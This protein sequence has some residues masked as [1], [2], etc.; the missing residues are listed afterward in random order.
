MKDLSIANLLG[1]KYPIFQGGIAWVSDANLASA[2]SNAGGLGIIAAGNAD[3]NWLKSEI[4]KA[5]R[6]TDKPLGVNIMLLSP[7]VEEVVKLVAESSIEVI[8]TGAGNPGPYIEKWQEAGK[9]VI[10]VVSS[11]ALAKRLA[12]KGVDA[13]IAEGMEAGGHIGTTTTMALVPQIR[14]AINI[15]VIAAG[16]IAD[17][18]GIVAALALGANGVQIGTRFLVA[19]ECCIH[20]NYKHKV[21]TAT[22]RSTVIS[23]ESTGHPV[24]TLKNK[25]AREYSKLEKSGATLEELEQLGSGK[26]K[27][28]VIDGDMDYGSPMAG[29]VAGL[30][31]KEQSVKEIIDELVEGIHPLLANIKE[32]ATWAK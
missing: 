20:Q 19:R 8:V 15:P 25:L 24:R 18:R 1:I 2:V 7:H 26:L 12:D 17:S 21:I 22:D 5:Q 4:I 6:L 27:L 31:C 29:Q 28:A 30:I 23:G 3:A 16:G 11:V 9:K 13:I 10:P 14:D 32:R